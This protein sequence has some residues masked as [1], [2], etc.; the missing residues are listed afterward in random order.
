[1]CENWLILLVEKGVIRLNAEVNM[2]FSTPKLPFPPP[3]LSFYFP[4]HW[5]CTITPLFIP[6]FHSR[7]WLVTPSPPSS[8]T[9]WRTGVA[10]A[11]RSV[12]L[13]GSGGTRANLTIRCASNPKWTVCQMIPQSLH[14]KVNKSI[15]NLSFTFIL[16]D[17][18][19]IHFHIPNLCFIYIL[20][21]VHVSYTHFHIS[22]KITTTTTTTK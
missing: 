22:R 6:L 16:Y 10:T 3:P 11:Q 2:F 7:T 5:S 4:N 19:Y 12:F 1:M 21:N 9:A 13:S 14:L 20:Y 15:T 17:V 18:S 8:S